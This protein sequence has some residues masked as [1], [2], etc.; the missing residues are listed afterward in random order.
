MRLIIVIWLGKSTRL[1]RVQG[2]RLRDK[3]GDTHSSCCTLSLIS[4]FGLRPKQRNY[5]VKANSYLVLENCGHDAGLYVTHYSRERIP[6]LD[7]L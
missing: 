3:R 4:L 2:I 6:K 5:G 7:D 1:A